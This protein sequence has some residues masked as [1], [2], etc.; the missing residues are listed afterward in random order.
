MQYK[1]AK[2][3][4]FFIF[5]QYEGDKVESIH[6]AALYKGFYNHWS[7]G[8][9]FN[10]IIHECSTYTRIGIKINKTG[11]KSNGWLEKKLLYGLYSCNTY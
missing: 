11:I 4:Y 6:L 1:G 8:Q 7:I 2:K 9:L 3:I 5:M 10:E